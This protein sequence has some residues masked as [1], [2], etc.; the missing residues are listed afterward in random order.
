MCTKATGVVAI[1]ITLLMGY[2]E[3]RRRNSRAS[4]MEVRL[5]GADLSTYYWGCDFDYRLTAGDGRD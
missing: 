5:F 1:D 4:A 3:L 2:M